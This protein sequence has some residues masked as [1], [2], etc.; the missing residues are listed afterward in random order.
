MREIKEVEAAEPS[1]FILRFPARSPLDG[2]AILT[3]ASKHV[4]LYSEW[5]DRKL[6][7]YKLVIFIKN[8]SCQYCEFFSNTSP[9]NLIVL[10]E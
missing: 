8:Q 2:A 7:L 10:Q 6:V 9:F 4:I 1:I 5:L 3:A